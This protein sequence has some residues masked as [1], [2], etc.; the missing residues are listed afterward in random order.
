[1]L[2]GGGDPSNPGGSKNLQEALTVVSLTNICFKKCVVPKTHQ[3]STQP[4]ALNPNFE[5]EKVTPKTRG[6]LHMLDLEDPDDSWALGER[7]TVCMHN[8]SKSMMELKGF[9]HMQLLKDYTTVR[10]KNRE[11]FEDI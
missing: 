2:S 9:L 3:K 4:G 5:G 10:K 7:E 6:V 1:M 11:A 8:C